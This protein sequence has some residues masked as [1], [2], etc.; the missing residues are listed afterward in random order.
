MIKDLS[1]LLQ[2]NKKNMYVFFQKHV[3][4]FPKRRTCFLR[5]VLLNLIKEATFFPEKGKLF[6]VKHTKEGI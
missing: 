3:N 1:G 5:R 6:H 2:V 4:V